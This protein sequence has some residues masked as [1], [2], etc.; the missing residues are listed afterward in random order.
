MYLLP[1]HFATN[2]DNILFFDCYLII[3]ISQCNPTAIIKNN[4]KYLN[5]KINRNCVSEDAY[6]SPSRYLISHIS[7]T[8]TIHFYLF[9]DA[10]SVTPSLIHYKIIV[11]I[12]VSDHIQLFSIQFQFQCFSFVCMT[13]LACAWKNVRFLK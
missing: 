11:Y 12:D 1:D 5:M 13:F 4:D 6:R 3:V 2:Y 9:I 10:Y 8:A 7:Q